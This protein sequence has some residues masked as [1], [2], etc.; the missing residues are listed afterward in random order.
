[1][2]VFEVGLGLPSRRSTRPFPQADSQVSR[3]SMTES[4]IYFQRGQ[5]QSLC[6]IF[7]PTQPN[8]IDF[9]QAGPGDWTIEVGNI[10]LATGYDLF[11]TPQASPNTGMGR[12]ANV[13][14]SLEFERMCERRPA[15]RTCKVV[16]ARWRDPVPE[17]QW[18][19]FIVSEAGIGTTTTTA[20][21]IC[22]MQSLKFAHVVKERTGAARTTTS[23]STCAPP[24][25][26][27][28]RVLSES[29]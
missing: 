24:G 20:P 28:R 4:C 5:M 7:C 16:L 11:D 9:D 10:I 23:T 17:N 3:S 6:Q 15:Q 29:P 13:F 22:C 21:S 8:A 27:L 2:S 19:S 14:T 12:L 1:M 26:G 18:A 25:Q